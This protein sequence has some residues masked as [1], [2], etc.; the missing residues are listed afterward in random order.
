MTTTQP[1]PIL[2]FLFLVL[3]APLL[4]ASQRDRDRHGSCEPC[5]TLL[6]RGS[7]SSRKREYLGPI[8]P[9]DN[10][11]GVLPVRQVPTRR[12]TLLF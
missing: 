6:L 11:L 3:F 8:A 9:L 2:A 5:I 4:C 12:S 7:C 1:S 10:A